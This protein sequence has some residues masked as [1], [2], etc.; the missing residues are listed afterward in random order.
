MLVLIGSRA[1]FFYNRLKNRLPDDWDF[2]TDE[3]PK[4]TVIVNSE[5]FDFIDANDSQEKTNQYIFEYCIKYSKNELETPL[6][7]ALVAPLEILKVLKLGSL[8]IE[9]AKH[10][11][12][13]SLLEDI[14]LS[15]ELINLIEQRKKETLIKVELQKKDFFDK[16]KIPRFFDHDVL[17]RFISPLPAYLKV[18]E[19]GDPVNISPN[20]FYK[21]SL[22]EQKEIIWEETLALALE[23]DLIPRIRSAPYL[24]EL[25]VDNFLK[26]ST[27]QSSALIWLGK[28]SIPGKIKYHPDWIA[29]WG[30]ENQKALLTGFSEWWELKVNGLPETFWEQLLN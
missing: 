1:L 28:L 23:R 22:L 2:L 18:L 17:H 14:D 12:D 13:L 3:I 6:G 16:Y 4:K 27:S 26:T 9:K 10:H 24:I 7:K 15:Q 21:L 8:P 5:I 29:N 25:L 19:N 11:W 20:K 30:M